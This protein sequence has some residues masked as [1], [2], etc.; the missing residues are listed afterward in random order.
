MRF[1]RLPL[2]A[3][4]AV[5]LAATGCASSEE[6]TT[7]RQHPTHFASGEHLFFSTRNQ[8]ANAARVTRQDI[9]VARNEG[10]WGRPVTVSQEQI[11]ER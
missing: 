11:L 10:W 5:L 2:V 8:A 7:W 3:I 4:A 1:D 9:Q 6:W